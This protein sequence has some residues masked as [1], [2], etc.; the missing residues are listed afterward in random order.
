MG[1]GKNVQYVWKCA[2][3]SGR[4]AICYIIKIISIVLRL[5]MNVYIQMEIT[6]LHLATVNQIVLLKFLLLLCL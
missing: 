6:K 1:K 5:N 2:A 3:F 4:Q